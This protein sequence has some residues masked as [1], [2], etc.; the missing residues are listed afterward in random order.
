MILYR[1]GVKG[2]LAQ[3]EGSLTRTTLEGSTLLL[4]SSYS[5]TAATS[6]VAGSLDSPRRRH[7]INDLLPLEILTAIF[8]DISRDHILHLRHLFLVCRS[9]SIVVLQEA[10]LWSTIRIDRELYRHFRA[11]ALGAGVKDTQATKFIS[12]C[13]SRSKSHLLSVILDFRSF[14]IWSRTL[15]QVIN[16]DL[17]KLIRILVGNLGQ[18]ALRWQSLEWH[19]MVELGRASEIISI[20]PHCLPQLRYLRLYEF[21]WDRQSDLSFPHCPSLTVVELHEHQEYSTR[22]LGESNCP[23]IEE[24]HIESKMAWYFEDLRYILA[25]RNIRRLTLCSSCEGAQVAPEASEKVHLPQVTDLRLEGF[26][27]LKLV[28][29]LSV[30]SLKKVDFDHNEAISAILSHLLSTDIESIS[31]LIPPPGLVS[32]QVTIATAV[33]SLIA[34][35]HALKLLRVKRWIYDVIKASDHPSDTSGILSRGIRV[36]IE[37]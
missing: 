32:R 13:I 24:L 34:S 28:G 14:M 9:W 25:F 11:P 29:L 1:S 16:L 31:A 19:S 17:F 23:I 36:I 20:L 18:H 8:S 21:Q 6:P 35:L 2:T 33:N 30:P 5:S 4:M 15:G 37:D 3:R 27:H 7:N 10:E 22:L 12:L 26:I